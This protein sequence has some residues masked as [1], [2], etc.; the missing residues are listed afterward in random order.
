M[1]TDDV[2]KAREIEAAAL[3]LSQAQEKTIQALD[4]VNDLADDELLPGTVLFLLRIARGGMARAATELAQKR[5]QLRAG[6]GN[7]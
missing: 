2:E 3:R 5:L 4:I 1:A 6:G 7:G